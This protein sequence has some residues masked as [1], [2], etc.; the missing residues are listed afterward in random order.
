[1]PIIKLFPLRGAHSAP[2]I[3]SGGVSRTWQGAKR[4]SRFG[5]SEIGIPLI[6]KLAFRN[7]FHD[8]L[9][10]CA[11]LIGIVFSVVLVTVQAGLHFG[12]GRM[13]TAMI[14]HASADLWVMPHGTKC[15]EDPSLFDD[16][17]RFRVRAIDGVVD[18][19]PLVTG[20][21]D[22]R[23]PSGRST[24]VFIIGSDLKSNGLLP[25]NLT[26]GR[27][28]DLAQ[29]SSVAVDRSYLDRLGV[30]GLGASAEIRRQTVRVAAITEGI[31]SFTTTP[32]V[33]M[34]LDRARSYT[35]I[36]TNEATF[37]LVPL[38]PRADVASIRNQILATVP[39]VDVLTPTEFGERSRSFWLFGTGA[40]AA[41]LAGAVL[42]LIVGT[43]IV[44]QTLYS[45][46]KEHLIEF[47]TLRA[48]GSSARYICKVIILQA[49]I[50]AVVGF[51]VTALIDN[52]IIRM[53][54]AT[55]LPILI[56]PPVMLASFTLTVA[57][58]VGSALL[59]I[60]QVTRIDPAVV[61]R[62]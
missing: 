49:L 55:S 26:A 61:F 51:S 8:R 28:E 15:F 58:C 18:A 17:K 23:M 46:T 56:T 30:S 7:L 44:A 52:G 4:R 11:T 20:F 31:R 6:P 9:R 45:S 43:I 36:S 47:A 29:A 35:G 40:G 37:I 57:M 42:G 62:R 22:W 24:P 25:W 39:D 14:D 27:V 1:M 2:Q 54:A 33:F 50:S 5:I 12:F 19:V 13:V 32:F 10:F 34:S 41:L 48:I 16:R 59:A 53:T 3:L 38:D 21:A 60:I